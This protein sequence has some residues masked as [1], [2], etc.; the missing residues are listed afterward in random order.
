METKR[1]KEIIVNFQNTRIKRKSKK[2]SES[3]TNSL[4]LSITTLQT[5]K[6]WRNVFTILQENYFQ[7]K[8]YTQSNYQ[9]SIRGSTK[10]FSD[11]PSRE[12]FAIHTRFLRKL[13]G[14]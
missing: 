1:S 11:M 5:G 2:F 8:L 4:V 6:Q 7:L 9:S 13:L 12:M 3:K 14:D 10:T